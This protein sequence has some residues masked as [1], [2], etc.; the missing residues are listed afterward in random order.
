MAMVRRPR[1]LYRDYRAVLY[2]NRQ[3]TGRSVARTCC[4]SRIQLMPAATSRPLSSVGVR[5]GT[6]RMER[7]LPG[8]RSSLT[9]V[10]S[11]PPNLWATT[12]TSNV[13][14]LIFDTIPLL[15]PWSF[16]VGCSSRPGTEGHALWLQSIVKITST[17]RLRGPGHAYA[18][19]LRQFPLFFRSLLFLAGI[20]ITLLQNT[21]PSSLEYST[22]V[23]E[24]WHWNGHIRHGAC[25]D[26]INKQTDR[27]RSSRRSE[28]NSLS[29][30]WLENP[31]VTGVLC[32]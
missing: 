3:L 19:I 8:E 4:L 18:E 20:P 9:V 2:V 21:L 7:P 10:S 15:F 26:N 28:S 5:D 16:A 22:E 27:R 29:G 30:G 14:M 17:R 31:S 13:L 24:L 23:S 12:T 32:L 25:G 6:G 1:Q 11:G